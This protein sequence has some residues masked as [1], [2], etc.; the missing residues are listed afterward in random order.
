MRKCE[1]N[2]VVCG[3]VSQAT[4]TDMNHQYCPHSMHAFFTECSYSH[5]VKKTFYWYDSWII[6]TLCI[7]V[8]IIP[9]DV[10]LNY[11]TFYFIFLILFNLFLHSRFYPHP[12]SPSE[13]SPSHSSSLHPVFKSMSPPSNPHTTR[14][15]NSLGPQI[16]WGLGASSLTESRST[17]PLL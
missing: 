17:S 4:V 3:S 15:L 9:L 6:H 11:W 8:A 13:C 1:L 14:P 16:S 7:Y 10:I 5:P 12:S 2:E